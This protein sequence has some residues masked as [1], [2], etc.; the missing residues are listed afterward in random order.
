[1]DNDSFI[2]GLVNF[3]I[4]ADLAVMWAS[5]AFVGL[6]AVAGVVLLFLRRWR[7][8][9]ACLGLA[10]APYVLHGL[11]VARQDA[12]LAHRQ[13]ELAA[14]PRTPLT[15]DHPRVLEAQVMRSVAARILPMG[16]FDVVHSYE[17]PI[18]PERLPERRTAYRWMDTAECAALAADFRAGVA[19]GEPRLGS[20]DYALELCV[21]ETRTEEAG[22]RPDAVL[23]L[24]DRDT[25]FAP[26]GGTVWAGGLM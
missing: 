24:R 17:D 12:G 20:G 19:A 21:E 13:A 8:A 9:A 22:P 25:T 26:R 1:M 5:M 23:F 4:A 11:A 7:W 14:L 18:R 2:R 3:F 15:A 16:R 10:A 6:M